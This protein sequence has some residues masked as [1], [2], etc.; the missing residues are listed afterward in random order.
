[1]E[2]S[3]SFSKLN[4]KFFLVGLNKIVIARFVRNSDNVT[5]DEKNR[6]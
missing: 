6:Y 3:K 1:M 4:K 2:L 5:V